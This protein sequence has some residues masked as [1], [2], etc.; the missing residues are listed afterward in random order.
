[1][2]N[3]LFI[4]YDGM[5]DPL[6]QSQ[7]IPYL[8]GLCKHGFRFT[9]L[10]CDK[11]EKFALYKKDIER[12]L[13]ASP[14]RWVS[15]A[16]HKTPPVLSAAYD[17]MMLQRKAAQ[18]HLEDPFDLVHTRAGT[19]ALVGLWMKKKFGVKFL[20]DL[21][22]FFADSRVDSGSWNLKNPVFR[23][24]YHFFK[25]KEAEAI[26]M[27]DGIV[28][29]TYVAEKIIKTLPEYKDKIPLQVIPCSVDMHLFN[30]ENI[31]ADLKETITKELQIKKDAIIISY[32]GSIGGWYLTEEMMA[33]CKVI[34]DKNPGAK[35]LFITPHPPQIIFEKAKAHGM[36]DDKI[37]V[38]HARRHEVPVLLS[39]SSYSLFFI[40]PCFSKQASSPTKH[41]EI[42]AMGIPLITN[43]GVGD[44]G[45][46]VK[47]YRS[48]IVLKD[49][50]EKNYL[51]T[52]DRLKD[53][54]LFNSLDIRDGAK[55][56]YNLENAVLKY[57]EIYELIL[58]P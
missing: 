41:G 15:I 30:P 57:K 45:N 53:R 13:N 8:I 49:L 20:N 3:I 40:Q 37:L 5:T 54:H 58:N 29:L 50:N 44:V 22:D 31:D 39:L 46:I 51:E 55:Q 33:F 48:G 19:P 47:K 2:K 14:I 1:M 11:P 23:K 7:V 36:R 26:E 38:R 25:K 34:S 43:E 6:G 21:R 24:V 42:M 52:A 32:L 9:I 27:N 17:V 10:S 4:S 28:C 56:Y 12:I 18:L 35:F 16:Y